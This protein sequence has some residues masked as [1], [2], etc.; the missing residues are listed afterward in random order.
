MNEA[1]SFWEDAVFIEHNDIHEYNEANIIAQEDDTIAKIRSWLRPTDFNSEGSE[2]QK[3]LSSHLP[4]TGAWVL[5]SPIYQQWHESSEHGLL[6]VRG[7]KVFCTSSRCRP[8][9]L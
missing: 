1:P 6:W 8:D 4:G 9:R 2:Y 7:T 5:A 3:H